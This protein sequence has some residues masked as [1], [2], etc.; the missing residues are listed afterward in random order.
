MKFIID[1]AVLESTAKTLSRVINTKNPLPILRCILFHV[2]D[3]VAEMTAYDGDVHIQR[4]LPLVEKVNEDITFCVDAK[5]LTDA[6]S[7]VTDQPVT[8]EVEKDDGIRKLTIH[9]QSGQAFFP[10]D[11]EQEYPI[12]PED[13]RNESLSLDF[14]MVIAALKRSIW[15]TDTADLRPAMCGVSF[16]LDDGNISI[17]AT[18]GKSLVKTT[19]LLPDVDTKRIG[20]FIMPKK[21][22]VLL[23]SLSS[24]EDGTLYIEWND[25][26]VRMDTD[27]YILTF[28]QIEGKY[29]NYMSVIRATSPMNPVVPVAALANSV[30]KVLP[31]SCSSSKLL[32]MQFDHNSL[33]IAAEDY[34]FFRGAFDQLDIEYED[35]SFT[36]GCK[37][38]QLL[39]MLSKVNSSQLTIGLHDPDDA[40]IINDEDGDAEITMLLMPMLLNN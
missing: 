36:I 19:Q 30:K 10:L 4:T 35:K 31:L 13:N 6:L 3:G 24:S 8:I 40:I 15:A 32:S 16:A 21:A 29:P 34:D 28:N 23:T 25:K 5:Y 11:D 17:V 14:A 9:H 20:S 27:E 22:A 18:D 2:Y 1:K 7:A 38:D 37:G 26:K 33:R 39:R 12:L